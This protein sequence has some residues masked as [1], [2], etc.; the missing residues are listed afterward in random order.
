MN[1][2]VRQTLLPFFAL[3]LVLFGF[4]LAQ[5]A[6]QPSISMVDVRTFNPETFRFPGGPAFNYQPGTA[7]VRQGGIVDFTNM[8][9]EEHTATSYTDKMIVDFEGVMVS[10][11]IPDGKFNSGIATPIESG[12]TWT[13]DTSSLAP[14]DYNYFCLIHPWMQALLKIVERNAPTSITVNMDHAI[15]QTSQFFAGSGSWGFTPRTL[16]VRQGTGITVVDKGILLHTIT[17]YT[18]TF[19]FVEGGHTL[20]IPIPNGTFDSGPM[21]PGQTYTLNTGAL[22]KGT[23]TY[24]C[25]FHP[26]MLGSITVA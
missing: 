22:S 25:Q 18:D 6:P 20:T 13:L 24:F 1:R 3:A 10:M 8:G 17:S 4:P 21:T 2:I 5:A 15:G 26:W 16:T 14:G 9:F 7:T 23:Y 12:D 19:Q 11:P